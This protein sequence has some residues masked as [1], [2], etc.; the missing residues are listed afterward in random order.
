[1]PAFSLGLFF[2]LKGT[3]PP[4]FNL[5]LRPIFTYNTVLLF[6]CRDTILPFSM[7]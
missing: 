2:A 1:M 3:T 4:Y 5:N 6:A 7:R